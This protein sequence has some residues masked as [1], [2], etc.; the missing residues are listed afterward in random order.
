MRDV[1]AGGA[2]R[3]GL[4]GRGGGRAAAPASSACARGASTSSSRTSRCPTSTG[5]TCCARSRRSR[6]RRTSSPSPRSA[7]STPPSAPSSWARSTTSP[8]RST[9]IRAQSLGAEGAGRAGAALR[10]RAAARR[11][12]EELPLGEHH[13]AFGGDAGDVRGHPAAL[14]LVDR[15]AHHRR[16]GDGQGAGRQGDPLQQPAARAAVRAAQLRRHPRHAARE[17]AVRLQARRL[18]RRARRQV[19]HVRRGRRG[20]ALPRRDRRAVAGAA[21]QAAAR[22][23][24]R[25]RSGRS[26]RRAARRST[27]ASSPPPTRIWRRASATAPSA[28][29]STTGSTSSTST[30]RRCAIGRRTSSTWPSTSWRAAPTKAGKEIRGFHETAR[31]ALLAYGWPGN[32][33]ELENVVERAVALTESALV[34]SEDLP[35][36]RARA[37]RDQRGRSRRRGGARADARRARARVHQ[38]R[39]GGRGGQQDARRA[40]AGARP[41]DALPQARRVRRGRCAVRRRRKAETRDDG[42]TFVGQ[43]GGARRDGRRS[44]ARARLGPALRPLAP[45]RRRA[46]DLALRAGARSRLARSVR[47]GLGR[48]LRTRRPP[49]RIRLDPETARIEATPTLH[50]EGTPGAE[51]VARAFGF[52]G[53]VTVEEMVIRVGRG[54]HRRRR[55]C[56]ISASAPGPFRAPAQALELFEATVRLPSRSL[57]PAVLIPWALRNRGRAPRWDGA[58]HLGGLALPSPTCRHGAS[59]W[60]IGP[61][62]CHRQR[63]CHRP[64]FRT[65]NFPNG[66]PRSPRRRLPTLLRGARWRRRAPATAVGAVPLGQRAS[67]RRRGSPRRTRR[68]PAEPRSHRP[69][70]ASV[71]A[72]PNTATELPQR[73]VAAKCWSAAKNAASA[74]SISPIRDSAIPLS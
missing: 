24:R 13:R 12:P 61:C 16:L 56:R 66:V 45:A 68:R 19:R 63:G 70:I 74:P 65:H 6:R 31:K 30:C 2:G 60:H 4:H 46:P 15:R 21:G 28:R 43:L 22:A 72:R 5:S 32:V 57:A 64:T 49:V 73:S 62:R 42:R 69:A 27:C 18:H 1:P 44:A 48:R 55:A 20:H 54:R 36:D 52:R 17:R 71:W 11:G 26:A 38:A 39:A 59:A 53:A 8:S 51:A 25:G 33:R 41:Q 47:A 67:R 37:A 3:G 14:G 50:R 34:Q 35:A 29:I 40:A 58:R 7:R 10:G 23:C 9:S